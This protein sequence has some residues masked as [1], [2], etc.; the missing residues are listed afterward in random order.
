[1]RE[2]FEHWYVAIMNFNP[3]NL[4]TDPSGEYEL[5]FVSNMYT[6][7][8]G[9]AAAPRETLSQP[10]AVEGWSDEK[11]D[12]YVSKHLS[13]VYDC[14][15]DPYDDNS[16]GDAVH[17]IYTDVRRIF[18]LA[19]STLPQSEGARG[20]EQLSAQDYEEVLADHRRLV[21]ELDVLLNGE[22]GAAPQASLCDIVAQL[23]KRAASGLLSEKA[24]PIGY[25]SQETLE[26]LRDPE[27]QKIRGES[28]PVWTTDNPPSRCIYPVFTLPPTAQQALRMAADVCDVVLADLNELAKSKF[29]YTYEDS[30]DEVKQRILA[31]TPPTDPYQQARADGFAEGVKAAAARLKQIWKPIHDWD[32]YAAEE[33]LKLTPSQDTVTMTREEVAKMQRDALRWETF[34]Y[35]WFISESIE[36]ESDTDDERMH[37][38]RLNF[39]GVECADK[40]W[41]GEDLESI[42][43]TIK[44]EF[45]AAPDPEADSA[46]V[47]QHMPKESE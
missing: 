15:L 9:G 29:D 31:L 7:F 38:W 47:A 13:G 44:A 10:A 32:R 6:A 24:E 20:A 30:L 17:S 18:R 4:E 41:E 35:L 34:N 2:R 21:R 25:V 19:L 46:I 1:M 22:E 36:L 40:S 3:D 12:E 33:L 39:C 37:F 8:C 26:K 27:W 43:D 11:I 42:V 5:S 16:S 23:R 45:D 14:L 28:L